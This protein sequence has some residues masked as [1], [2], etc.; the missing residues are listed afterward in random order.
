MTPQETP[1]PEI[2]APPG[3]QKGAVAAPKT[4]SDPK[5]RPPIVNGAL[6]FGAVA[7]SFCVVW[8]ANLAALSMHHPSGALREIHE[9]LNPT[10][11]LLKHSILREYGDFSHASSNRGIGSPQA[12]TGGWAKLNQSAGPPPPTGR[13]QLSVTA[14]LAAA[15]AAIETANL[16]IDISQRAADI[17][18][19]IQAKVKKPYKYPIMFNQKQVLAGH[20]DCVYKQ[21]N[22]YICFSV[23]GPSTTNAGYVKIT[24]KTPDWMTWWKSLTLHTTENKFQDEIVWNQDYHHNDHNIIPFDYMVN[25]FLVLSKA[26]SWGIHTNM[27]WIQNSYELDPNYDWVIEWMQD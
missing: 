12:P 9:Q 7:V 1:P 17:I 24:L 15:Q 8:F 22:D 27:Y 4:S 10:E 18:W 14:A 20:R 3:V 23:A 16:A 25:F 21:D 19:D 13:R 11:A 2:A 6:T 5:R 26:K